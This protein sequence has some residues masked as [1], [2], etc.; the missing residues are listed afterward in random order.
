[1]TETFQP[2]PLADFKDYRFFIPDYQRGYR[3]TARE[4]TDLLEDVKDFY[5]NKEDETDEYYPLQPLVVK[6]RKLSEPAGKTDE[7][8]LYTI[9]GLEGDTGECVYEVIDGQQRLTTIYLLLQCLGRKDLV[10]TIRYQTRPETAKFLD[11]AKENLAEYL[12]K[13][14]VEADDIPTLET[15]IQ[16]R[17]GK[18]V[19]GPGKEVNNIDTFHMFT[20]YLTID[21]WFQRHAELNTDEGFF[22]TLKDKVK[23]IWYQDTQKDNAKQ[24]FQNL[25]SGKTQLT[26]AELIKGLFVQSLKHEHPQMP[27]L[28]Q[29]DFAQEWDQIEQQLGDDA[30]WFFLSNEKD[31][32]RYE[33][34][35]DLLFELKVGPDKEKRDRLRTYRHFG[36]LPSVDLPTAWEEAKRLFLQLREWYEHPGWYHLIGFILNVGIKS[37][38][39]LIDLSK[40][41]TKSEFGETLKEVI[42]EKLASK[43]K[44]GQF[45]YDLEALV[46]GQTN[47]QIHHL[48]LLHNLLTYQASEVGLRFPF[49]KFK[50]QKWSLEHIHPQNP[51]PEELDTIGK[52][53][54]W[55][56][57]QK[58]A[59]EAWT[60]REEAAKKLEQTCMNSDV[61]V[62]DEPLSPEQIEQ[63]DKLLS[64]VEETF[65]THHI[66]NLL[67]L[68]RDTNSSLGNQNFAEKRKLIL[69]KEQKGEI[70]FLPIC[71]RYGFLKYYTHEAASLAEWTAQD[72]QAYLA[73]LTRKLEPYLPKSA[74]EKAD[75]GDKTDIIT[76]PQS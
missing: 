48:L 61:E 35:I 64:Q 27:E 62:E 14:Q 23:F 32:T 37:I 59:F 19:Q 25:N 5:E 51:K 6:E 28:Q 53:R 11:N 2:R 1:M 4:V 40:E 31:A 33:T 7:R 17:W 30:F 54:K 9:F 38:P 66:S 20:A 58:A 22:H 69:E 70:P 63:R 76:E 43:G 73:D 57:G 46:Y 8:I 39:Q 60:S 13:Q 42:R 52:F 21:L 29:K 10:Y 24:V 36:N 71:T 16:E 55:W 68:D 3:W 65:Q 45:M 50:T 56:Q 67:L 15:V 41:K 26:N 12:L 74:P 49:Q 18:F 75:S 44:E 47:D 72:Q 34:R